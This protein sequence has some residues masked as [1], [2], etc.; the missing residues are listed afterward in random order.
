MRKDYPWSFLY[1]YVF[2]RLRAVRQDMVIQNIEGQDAIQILQ[3]AVRFYIYAG[4]R[5]ATDL[6]FS[7]L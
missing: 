6:T 4:Y 1:E 3:I 5:L 2:D 7:E